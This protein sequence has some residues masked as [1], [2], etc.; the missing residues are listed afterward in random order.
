MFPR[1]TEAYRPLYFLSALGMGGLSVSFFMYLMFL[2]PHPDSPIPT[3][4]HLAQV[5]AGDSLPAKV[6]LTLAVAAIAWFAVRHLQLLVVNLRAHRAFVRSDE[7]TKFRNS[8]GEVQMMAVPLT[9]AMTV[10]VV[11]ILGALFVPGLW[12]RKEYLFPAALVAMTA[13]GWYALRTFA[14]YIGRILSEGS[15]NIEDTNHF[16][17][18]LPAFA[19]AMIGVGYSSSA[20]M[21]K[22]LLWSVLGM[23]GTF[24]FFAATAAWILVKLPVSF[25]AM[26]RNGMAR[27]AGPTLWMGIPIFTL[28]GIGIFRVTAGIMHN[29]VHAKTPSEVW[30]VFFGLM[31]SAQLVMGGFGWA[32]MR[33][34]GYFEHFVRG[35]GKSIAAYGLI[36]P[37]VALAVLSSFLLGWGLVANGLVDKFSPLHYV[38]LGVIA[39]IQ[40]VTILTLVRLNRKL[41]SSPVERPSRSLAGATA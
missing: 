35:E 2:V 9:L 7:F 15:F 27:E 23:L 26:L 11:F 20:A 25:G 22:T 28:F 8:N 38:L 36:C 12:A 16:S 5:Y 3:Y 34:Q 29:M 6:A 32:V 1:Q 40:A 19:F 37:G 33:K 39:S 30:F 18:V 4:D 17:Q 24:I 13:I 14:A 41:Y 31:V 10:N 21:S